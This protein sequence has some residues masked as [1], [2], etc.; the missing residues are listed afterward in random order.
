MSGDLILYLDIDGVL[1]PEDVVRQGSRIWVRSP[2]GHELFEYSG[3]LQRL[4]EASEHPWKLVISS[5]WVAALGYQ[6]TRAGLPEGLRQRVVGCTDAMARK[7]TFIPRPWQ[8]LG[9]LEKRRPYAWIA[10]DDHAAWPYMADR[11]VVVTPSIAGISDP[12][13]QQQL[14][15]MLAEPPLSAPYL[16]Q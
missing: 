16:R 1:H 3:V 2:A 12:Q 11:H 8:I 10:L 14:A 13:A 7:V 15:T 6:E 9:D 4:L 5:S